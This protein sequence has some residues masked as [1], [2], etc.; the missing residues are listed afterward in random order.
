MKRVFKETPTFTQKVESYGDANILRSIQDAILE[1]LLIGS[2][3]A[4]TGGLRKFRMPDP[5]RGKGKRGGL[6]VI[7]L[8]LPDREVTYLLYLYGKDEA[9]DLS[10]N[11]KRA[12]KNLVSSIK[13]EKK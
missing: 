3:I 1:N 7:Y 11:E 2:T 9:E 6:R 4:G 8:D 10:A 12:F 5:S 13:G